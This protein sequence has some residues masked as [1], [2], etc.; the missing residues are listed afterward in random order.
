MAEPIYSWGFETILAK[1]EWVKS[2]S[3]LHHPKLPPPG[4]LFLP[5]LSALLCSDNVGGCDVIHMGQ[6]EIWNY[7]M[8]K[9]TPLSTLP[10]SQASDNDRPHLNGSNWLT[11]RKCPKETISQC[12]KTKPLM[13]PFEW[14][15]KCFQS[16]LTIA[17][18]A[19]HLIFWYKKQ[20]AYSRFAE[21]LPL[22]VI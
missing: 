6:W 10:P 19:L 15:R 5:P 13:C 1:A 7:V 22:S 2:R 4:Y 14:M 11:R 18:I 8:I 9:L 21:S 12:P 17:T 20:S 3:S 16:T